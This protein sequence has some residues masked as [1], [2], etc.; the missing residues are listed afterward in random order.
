MIVSAY[1]DMLCVLFV[2]REC[3][4]GYTIVLTFFDT[5]PHVTMQ[6]YTYIDDQ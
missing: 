4:H 2:M 1:A 5:V 3:M 6:I